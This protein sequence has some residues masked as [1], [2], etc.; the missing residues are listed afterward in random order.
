MISDQDKKIIQ[1]CIN[2]TPDAWERFIQR[3][4]GL[5]MWSIKSR[6]AK[7]DCLFT[8]DDIEDIRQ[9]VFVFLYDNNRLSQLK[10][11]SKITSWLCILS[12]N[13][14]VNYIKRVK[15]RV[16]GKSISIHEPVAD[17]RQP[18]FTIADTLHTKTLSPAE[19]LD[20]KLKEEILSDIIESMHPKEKLVLN[21]Y[22]TYENTI[23]E[24]SGVLSMPQGSVASIINRAKDKVKQFIVEKEIK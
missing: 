6:L 20:K 24:I 8:N 14:A 3:F 10:D 11:I 9:E 19:Q 23:K 7:S 5:V 18:D 1:D 2:N 17:S 15:G 16:A 22:F 12:G 21:L 13:I 4:S